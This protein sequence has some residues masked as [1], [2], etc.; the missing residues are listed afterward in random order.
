MTSDEDDE[1]KMDVLKPIYH[2]EKDPI[3]VE[4]LEE[5]EKAE[6]Q[7]QPVTARPGGPVQSTNGSWSQRVPTTEDVG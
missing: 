6:E 5:W 3:V 1:Y 4:N 7:Q 2:E